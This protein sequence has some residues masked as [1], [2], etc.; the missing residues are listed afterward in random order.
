[1]KSKNGMLAAATLGLCLLPTAGFAQAFCSELSNVDAFPDAHKWVAPVSYQEENGVFYHPK[2]LF[3]GRKF[4]AEEAA[5]LA[6]MANT[7]KDRGAQLAIVLTAPRLLTTKTVGADVTPALVD[8]IRLGYDRAISQLNELGIVA[9]N[10]M[11]WLEEHPGTME[12]FNFRQDT[13][14]SPAGAGQAALS[15]RARLE[16]D[17]NIVFPDLGTNF[18]QAEETVFEFLGAFAGAVQQV[19]SVEIEPEKVAYN[20]IEANASD[21]SA[22]SLLFG[23]VENAVNVALLGTS[24]SNNTNKDRFRWADAV[25]YALQT[26]PEN[27]AIEGGG[28]DTSFLHAALTPEKLTAFDLLVWEIPWPTLHGNWAPN[29]RQVLGTLERPCS[30]DLTR[31]ASRTISA[32]DG[33]VPLFEGVILQDKIELR[34]EDFE[35]GRLDLRVVNATEETEDYRIARLDRLPP[36]ANRAVW[37]IFLTNPAESFSNGNPFSVQIRA[38]DISQPQKLDATMCSTVLQ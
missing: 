11:E 29:L 8:D 32:A 21:V 17:T 2:D 34:F 15:L 27:L 35:I 30:G 33:W 18:V 10:I 26:Q 4:S 28:L 23:S 19:C 13:H 20:A 36:S 31:V 3:V 1:M 7:F 9:P 24:F 5:L 38:R 16:E 14:W 12:A 6:Q 22:E 25:S 37:S